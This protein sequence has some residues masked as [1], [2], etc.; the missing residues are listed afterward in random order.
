MTVRIDGTN[1]TANPAI[2]GADT[3][4]GLQLGTN[5]IKVVTN[6]SEKATF[7]STGN[8]VL[9]GGSDVRI[10][11]GSNGTTATNDR[12]HIRG[13]G[14]SV[15]LN[16][17]QN[18]LFIFEQNGTEELRIQSGGGISFNGDTATANA[19]DDYEEG[20]W[21]PTGV[22]TN[23]PSGATVS[24]TSS[25]GFYTK[26]GNQVTVT[27]IVTYSITGTVGNFGVTG[28][29]FDVRT[30]ASFGG[31]SAREN[32]AT[33]HMFHCE[34]I[35]DDQISVFR[36]YD[37]GTVPGTGNLVGSCFYYTD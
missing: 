4:T 30:S 34:D 26:I 1:S 2:T 11:L 15:K 5:E 20:T 37:N 3:D 29:P 18:G 33:G 28:L 27:F 35:R 7:D 14:D 25:S 23:N 13:D 6:G 9:D 22:L 16:T 32:S 12:N 19:L 31:G 17:C 8:F 21:T 36:R 24:T 10:E